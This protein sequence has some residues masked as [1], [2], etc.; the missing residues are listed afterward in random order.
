MTL[1]PEQRRRALVKRVKDAGNLF[2]D[3]MCDDTNAGELFDEAAAAIEAQAAMLRECVE[4][5][6]AMTTHFTI[7][8]NADEWDAQTK[9]RKTLTRAKEMLK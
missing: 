3:V 5:L 6:E 1:T 8:S 7:F 4:A 2:S 9:A